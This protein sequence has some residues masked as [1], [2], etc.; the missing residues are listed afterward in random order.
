MKDLAPDS[1]S[2][3]SLGIYISQGEGIRTDTTSS[4]DLY[5]VCLPKPD[6]DGQAGNQVSLP[7]VNSLCYLPFDHN[8][9]NLVTFA[10]GNQHGFNPRKKRSSRSR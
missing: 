4:E 1:D 5:D 8:G 9:H 2:E 7:F 10:M 3:N 6:P